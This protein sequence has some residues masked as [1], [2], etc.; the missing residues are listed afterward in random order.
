MLA[1]TSSLGWD[2]GKGSESRP[3][4]T[5]FHSHSLLTEQHT[6]PRVSHEKNLRCF[7]VQIE[8]KKKIRECRCRGNWRWIYRYI[9]GAAW[10]NWGRVWWF[11]RWVGWRLDR[12]T[13][14]QK[15]YVFSFLGEKQLDRHQ[16]ATSGPQGLHNCLLSCVQHGD[17]IL[18]PSGFI[19]MAEKTP[20]GHTHIQTHLY[21]IPGRGSQGDT[22]VTWLFF[23]SS[24][25]L[26]FF[27][28]TPPTIPH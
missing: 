1:V 27:L 24:F 8:A 23:F 9:Y 21:I 19:K 28:P 5:G 20:C 4:K 13:D 22:S 11:C 25:L 2:R 16:L 12:Q 6:T 18:I 26:P 7:S 15:G 14:A 17:M 10:K 3:R